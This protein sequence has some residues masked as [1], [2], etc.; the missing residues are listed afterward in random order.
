MP[1]FVY[2]PLFRNFVLWLAIVV[3]IIFCIDKSRQ[4]ERTRRALY[5]C[6]YPL[7]G[8]AVMKACQMVELLLGDG[9]A[10]R[11]TAM[12]CTVAA[13]ALYHKWPGRKPDIP[14]NKLFWSI[15]WGCIAVVAALQIAMICLSPKT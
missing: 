12:A 2:N 4:N 10:G 15:G 11:W 9:T 5:N 7:Y 13:A 8:A 1:S 6:V 14:F 3:L